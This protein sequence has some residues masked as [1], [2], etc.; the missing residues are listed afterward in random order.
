M[1]TPFSC[2]TRGGGLVR[3]PKR[4]S[5]PLVLFVG[6]LFLTRSIPGAEVRMARGICLAA[7]ALGKARLEP[8]ACQPQQRVA[9]Q[10]VPACRHGG[11][12]HALGYESY[13]CRLEGGWLKRK[14]RGVAEVLSYPVLLRVRA[15]RRDDSDH[16][17]PP[18]GRGPAPSRLMPVPPHRGKRCFSAPRGLPPRNGALDPGSRPALGLF[19][20]LVRPRYWRAFSPE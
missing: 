13:R 1:Q 2:E 20:Q 12:Q 19:H 14:F 7:F 9:G 18:G 3:S 5:G 10:G 15:R 17:R 11:V 6:S 8:R 4:R 16:A